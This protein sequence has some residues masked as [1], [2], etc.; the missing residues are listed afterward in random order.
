MNSENRNKTLLQ[1]IGIYAIGTFGT[2]IMSF[3]IVPLYTYYIATSDM[4]VYDILISTINLLTPII[5]LQISDAA[6]RWVIREDVKDKER[7]LRTTIQVLLINCTIALCIIIAVNRFLLP[8]P[9]CAYFGIVLLLSRALQTFQKLL[10]ALKKQMLFAVSGLSYTII[11]L[12]LNVIHL[13]VFHMGVEGLFQSAIIANSVAIIIILIVE[14]RLRLN[15]FRRV[16][17]E[18]VKE[19]YRYSIPLVPN[20]LNW[21][22]INF[23]DRYIV[24]FALGS[25]FNG[26]LAIAH[27]FPSLLQSTLGLVTNSW[28]DLS[29]ADSDANIGDYYT[30]VFQKLYRL[31]LTCLLFVIPATKVIIVLIMSES[32][33]VSC[34]YVAFYYLGTVFQSFSSF[35]GVGY[36]R[37]KQTKKAFTTSICGAIVNAVVNILLIRVIG[38]QAAAISTFIGFLV[39]WLV[40]EKQNREELKIKISWSEIAL[41]TCVAVIVSVLS[42]KF[43]LIPNIILSSA[44]LIVML[45]FNHKDILHI[46]RSVVGK[47]Q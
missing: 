9:F 35:Y 17:T 31:A 22:V 44:G 32:Y 41:L 3:F 30:V 23:S 5:T 39:M 4:G 46:I 27:K 29:V 1:G 12:V 2:K 15:I 34:D 16:D 25:S 6:Y 40:R 37:S 43:M 7:Y 38:L 36:L 33:K 47:V 28:Q 19:M 20:Y 45:I 42:I 13:C 8:I 18:L 10:R 11:F 26:L 24:L 14:P 21:W